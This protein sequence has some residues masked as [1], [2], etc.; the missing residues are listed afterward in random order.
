[1]GRATLSGS[2]C[3]LRQ[4]VTG[5][6]RDSEL[7]AGFLRVEEAEMLS[8]LLDSQGIEAWVEG[9]VASGLG[10]VLS[11]AGGGARL[12]VHAAD[13]A[14][15]REI[16]ATSGVFRGDGGTPAEIPEQEWATHPPP[17]VQAGADAPQAG[18]KTFLF[19]PLVVVVLVVVAT[20][21][22]MLASR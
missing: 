11:G 16:I 7:V 10:P 18:R 2:A 9:A 5:V 6:H 14:R 3:L 17:G 20:A 19:Y 13:A 15:A 4:E 22:R 1:L 12:V 21:L 8:E